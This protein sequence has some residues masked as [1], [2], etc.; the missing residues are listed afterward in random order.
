MNFIKIALDVIDT[1]TQALLDMKD[2]LDE[3]FIKACQLMQDCQGKI[4]V[5]GIGKS[6]LIGK[7][8]AATLSSTG[9]PAIFLH[10]TE[11]SHGDFGMLQANDLIL[12][13]SHSGNTEELCKLFPFIQAKR[14]AMI[15]M[16][17]NPQSILAKNASIVLN[18]GNAKEACPLGLAPTTSTTLS[19]VLGDALAIC[20][21]QA[22][23]FKEHDFALNHPGGSLGKK[24]I[25]AMSLAQKNTAIPIVMEDCMLPEA[26]IEVSR[27]KLGMT[28]VINQAKELVGVLTDGDI[29]RCLMN[30]VDIYQTKVS[31]IMN[32]HPITI[33]TNVLAQD[34]LIKMQKKAITALI[35]VNQKHQPEA[36]LHIH[37]LIRSGFSIE[38][39]QVE[40]TLS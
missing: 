35:I 36:V 18:Y 20:L 19:L 30:Q 9:T 14:V 33:S 38:G 11:A 28:C 21:L 5:S 8:I 4:I 29:R 34:A 31:A 7:K 39:A 40:S 22:K 27:K 3:S 1:E 24:F 12:A 16:T 17:S 2:R 15:A 26:L 37:H 25:Q 13:I 23:N 10:P 6:G 32:M